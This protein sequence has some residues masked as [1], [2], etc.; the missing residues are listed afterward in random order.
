MDSD[1]GEVDSREYFGKG[2]IVSFPPDNNSPD[3]PIVSLKA[4]ASNVQVGE[5]ITFTTVSSVLSKK[6]DFE[7][8]RYFKYDFDGDGIYDLTTN[9][10]TVKYT[11]TKPNP[12]KR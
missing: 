5:E 4:S 6:P 9:K 1:G 7:T 11:Y 8:T 12:D 3:V 10:D 2:P